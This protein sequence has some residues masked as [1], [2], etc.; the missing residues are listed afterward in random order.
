MTTP[1]KQQLAT[2]DIPLPTN[3]WS[4]VAYLFKWAGMMAIPI[5]FSGAFYLDGKETNR[6]LVEEMKSSNQKLSDVIKSN[7]EVNIARAE[8]LRLLT[9]QIEE[10]HDSVERM[11]PVVGDLVKTVNETESEMKLH[12]TIS[13]ENNTLLKLIKT[14]VEKIDAQ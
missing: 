3:L 1:T 6:M 9:A 7:L 8:A 4:F 10:G 13:Q 12:S 11:I 2:A 14:F 5:V